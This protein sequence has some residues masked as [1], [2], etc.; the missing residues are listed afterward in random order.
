MVNFINGILQSN[1]SA[2]E[3]TPIITARKGSVLAQVSAQQLKTTAATATPSAFGRSAIGQ[4]ETRAETQDPADNEE[5]T[6]T[7]VDAPAGPVDGDSTIQEQA[8][9]TAVIP[10]KAVRWANTLESFRSAPATIYSAATTVAT[11]LSSFFARANAKV[12]QAPVAQAPVDRPTLEQLLNGQAATALKT[13]N[14]TLAAIFDKIGCAD[15]GYRI[16]KFFSPLVNADTKDLINRI[17]TLETSAKKVH[18]AAN[19]VAKALSEGTVSVDGIKLKQE[20]LIRSAQTTDTKTANKNLANSLHDFM[21]VAQQFVKEQ[22]PSQGDFLENHTA[23]TQ[24]LGKL[25]QNNTVGVKVANESIN[26]LLDLNFMGGS[27]LRNETIS[28]ANK[29]EEAL[30]DVENNTK[31]PD[32]LKFIEQ[33][34]KNL[35]T[36][37]KETGFIM[38]RVLKKLGCTSLGLLGKLEAFAKEDPKA[39]KLPKLEAE[40]AAVTEKINDFAK[41]LAELQDKYI[42]LNT[43][44]KRTRLAFVNA[45]LAHIERERVKAPNNKLPSEQENTYQNYVQ[46]KNTI[47]DL[48]ALHK[49]IH[50]VNSQPRNVLEKTPADKEAV[51]TWDAIRRTDK[52]HQCAKIALD[53]AL[54]AYKKEVIAVFGELPPESTVF[55][56]DTEGKVTGFKLEKAEDGSVKGFAES[57][58]RI[59]KPNSN[60]DQALAQLNG[61]HAKEPA[62]RQAFA[63]KQ[64]QVRTLSTIITDF[65]QAV[66]HHRAN[67]FQV[68]NLLPKVL[69]DD[70]TECTSALNSQN[71]PNLFA[72]GEPQ[73]KPLTEDE[74][75]LGREP[76]ARTEGVLGRE[77]PAKRRITRDGA[78]S[79]TARVAPN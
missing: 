79:V 49:L 31:L 73:T 57:V 21:Q 7:R 19:K 63:E 16:Q 44:M 66:E 58:K 8:E 54:K 64:V 10:R 34:Q 62:L 18:E 48:E 26:D 68:S 4:L 33:L 5:F 55:E 53:D 45:M 67:K 39:L 12:A 22:A 46:N 14:F 13:K 24:V 32:V 3:L 35:G 42:D 43:K 52:D 76:P 56:K 28:F 50:E 61:I 11:T 17:S 65:K 6:S 74:G 15:A 60:L 41:K 37:E 59:A 38:A 2:I 40:A 29:V 71:I 78:Q 75:V 30:A 77:P 25:I 9:Q 70:K 36:S 1:Q 72:T 27:I 23:Y 69:T 47:V 20:E 51:A